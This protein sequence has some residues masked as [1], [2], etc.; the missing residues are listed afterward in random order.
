M[1]DSLKQYALN[2]LIFILFFSLGF[3]GLWFSPFLV[4]VSTAFILIYMLWALNKTGADHDI[5][6]LLVLFPILFVLTDYFR[7]QEFGIVSS[8]LLLVCGFAVLFVGFRTAFINNK[9]RAA[10][11]NISLCV[12]L[13]VN[14]LAVSNYLIKKE[15][16]DELLLQSKAIPVLNMHHIHFGI[17]N[18]FS[19]ILLANLII[20]DGAV[21]KSKK[22]YLGVGF[23]I[24]ICFHIL[25]SRTGLLS[26]YG[27]V[28]LALVV[29]SI[30]TKNLKFLGF[31]SLAAIILLVSAYTLSTSFKNKVSNSKEDLTSLVTGKDKN[32]KSMTMRVEAYKASIEVIKS[33]FVIGVGSGAMKQ[34]LNHKYEEINTELSVEN[35]V[36]PHNQFLEYGMKYGVFGMLWLITFCIVHVIKAYKSSYFSLAAVLMLIIA[37]QFESLFE[38]Q[39]SIHFISFFMGIALSSLNR[40]NTA[41]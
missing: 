13:I 26:F 9:L 10:T 34:N 23:I 21:L 2:H 25:S 37:L 41:I 6:S 5:L 11:L 31:G 17:I 27:G 33:S 8:E 40:K 36:G 22:I 15:M 35:R 38:R 24:L 18:A 20:T 3:I 28:F 14:I 16:Y 29:F 19:V 1:L 30:R 32:Y 39:A 4:S 12:V 7:T